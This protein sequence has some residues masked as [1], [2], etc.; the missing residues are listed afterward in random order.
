MHDLRKEACKRWEFILGEENN[1]IMVRSY[2]KV[3]HVRSR[4]T[5]RRAFVHESV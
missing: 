1:K 5:E 3:N 4:A 2:V